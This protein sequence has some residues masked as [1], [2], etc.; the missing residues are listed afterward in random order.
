MTI[1]LKPI[2]YKVTNIYVIHLLYSLCRGKFDHLIRL[3]EQFTWEDL[4][5]T[6]PEYEETTMAGWIKKTQIIAK[7]V[8][9]ICLGFHFSQSTYRILSFREM[10][11]PS[12][13]PFDTTASP[14]YEIIVFCQVSVV[15]INNLQSS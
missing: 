13:Y 9:V 5:V 11:F 7:H 3:T 8:Y 15:N 12:R 2:T 1:P 4:P 14:A 10:V 6:D